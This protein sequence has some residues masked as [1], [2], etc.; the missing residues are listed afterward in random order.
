MVQNVNYN[1]HQKEIFVVFHE[2]QIFFFCKYTEN[3][4]IGAQLDTEKHTRDPKTAS[5]LTGG[6]KH[7]SAPTQ[8]IPPPEETPPSAALHDLSRFIGTAMPLRSICVCTK[9]A[10]F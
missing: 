10:F 6:M 4:G 8:T 1:L 3:P 7:F 2:S 9:V 5:V